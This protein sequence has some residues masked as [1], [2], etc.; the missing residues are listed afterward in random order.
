MHAG[1]LIW[2]RGQVSRLQRLELAL[3]VLATA[4]VTGAAVAGPAP[5]HPA[6]AAPPS[7]APALPVTGGAAPPAPPDPKSVLD[8]AAD[9]E[10]LPRSLVEAV[11]WWESGWDPS[12]V[13]ATGAVGMMQVQPEAAADMAPRLVGRQVDLSNPADNALVGAAMLR[14]YIGDF[15]GDTGLG[16]AAYYQGEGSVQQDGL[17]PDT[18]QYVDGI[19]ALQQRFAA[20]LPPPPPDTP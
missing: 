13:S 1:G 10:Q 19:E 9:Q 12:R 16:L 5:A 3:T 2:F 7:P 11:A 8:A 18:Q 20:G 14:A 4:T 15:G 6:S 17:Y